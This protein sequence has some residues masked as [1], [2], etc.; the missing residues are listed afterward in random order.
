[1]TDCIRAE[2]VSYMARAYH[3]CAWADA[4]EEEGRSLG[5]CEILDVMPDDEPSEATKAA[6]GLAAAMEKANDMTL[7]AI[8]ARGTGGD[9][10]CN[11]EMF[12]HYAAMQAMGHGVGLESVGISSHGP[13]ADVKVPYW[14][15]IML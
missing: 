14:E 5:G 6:E 7:V 1:M 10:P 2:I 15:S 9:R 4:E 12:G 11:P 8:M 3:A 13:K